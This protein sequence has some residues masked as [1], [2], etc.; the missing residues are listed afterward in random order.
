MEMDCIKL[1]NQIAAF[2][3]KVNIDPGS[4]PSKLC[5]YANLCP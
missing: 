5:A 1:I 2:I 3:V 4:M